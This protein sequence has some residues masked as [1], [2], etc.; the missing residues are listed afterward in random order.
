[1]HGVFSVKLVFWDKNKTGKK[2]DTFRFWFLRFSD[3]M[4]R[5]CNQTL[6]PVEEVA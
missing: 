6:I 1:M 2:F 3:F 5:I 4:E